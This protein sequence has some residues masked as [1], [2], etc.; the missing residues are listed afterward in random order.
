MPDSEF[1]KILT[2][3]VP[4]FQKAPGAFIGTFSFLI[5]VRGIFSYLKH[6]IDRSKK[7]EDETTAFLKNEIITKLD[8]I[9]DSTSDIKEIKADVEKITDKIFSI[10]CLKK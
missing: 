7:R 8:K 2:E 6:K 9:Q 4:L 5:T 10:K 1:L 3:L